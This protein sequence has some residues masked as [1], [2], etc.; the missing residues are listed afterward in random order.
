MLDLLMVLLLLA[1]AAL[2]LGLHVGVAGTAL[3][4]R[5][6][7]AL[8][9]EGRFTLAFSAGSI[10]AI[11]LLVLAWREAPV[12][13]LWEVPA[14]LRWLIAALMLPAA[15]LFVASLI[16]ANPTALGGRLPEGGPRG[17]TRI[18]RHPMLWSFAIWAACHIA[19]NGDLAG[20]IF[21]G[22]FLLTAL[23]GMPSI[24]RKLARRRPELW[25]DLAPASSILPFAAILAGRTRAD[26]A[27]IGW[28]AP[29]VGGALWLALLL[30]H[31][32]IFGVPAILW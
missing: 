12:I 9:G 14:W 13:P 32:D 16:A 19:G 22:A 28:L 21:F 30:L 5:A 3:R 7:A 24:D 2:W 25:R 27:G 18:T 20:L 1:A 31:R 10:L 6:V 15:V 23:L 26:W 11:A 8:G 17:I 4:E 29:A